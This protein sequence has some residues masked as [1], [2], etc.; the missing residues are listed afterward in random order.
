M[1]TPGRGSKN[2][3]FVGRGHEFA[4]LASALEAAGDGHG[5]LCLVSGE[6]GIGKSRLLTEFTAEQARKG[7]SIHWGFAWEAGGAPGYWP[8]IQILRSV[9]AQE[10]VR[11]ALQEHP[12]MAA[13]VGDLV[14]ELVP[15]FGAS[16]RASSN[17]S[18]RAS[19]SWTRYPACC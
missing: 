19:G 12:H 18:R 6:P 13:S 10:P 9:L 1:C 5:T 16:Q 14:P 4:A 11:A 3:A 15:E 8:W 7:T 2:R 17:P